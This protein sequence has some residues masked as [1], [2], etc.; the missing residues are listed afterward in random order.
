MMKLVC[1]VVA[2]GVLVLGIRLSY[3][4]IRGTS[5]DFSEAAWSG[6]Q[7]CAPCHAS[8]DSDQGAGYS[9]AHA[10]P[11]DSVFTKREGSVLGVDSLMCLGCHD[12]QTALDRFGDRLGSAVMTGARA[13]G[14][15]IRN[16][17]PVGVSYP[18]SREGYRTA[19]NVGSELQLYDGRIECGSCHDPHDDRNGK[20]LRVDS[21]VLCQLCHD[22]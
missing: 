4:G 17:H 15:D 22:L 20:F 3:G 13:F 9:W 1:L 12:G 8:H 10:Y 18:S 16:S 7:M 6:G 19:E 2:S 21:R 5:H 11:S 14:R